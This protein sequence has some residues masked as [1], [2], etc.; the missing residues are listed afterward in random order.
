MKYLFSIGFL[1]FGNTLFAQNNLRECGTPSP[2]IK[3]VI[4]PEMLQAKDAAV[5]YST[6]YPIKVFIIVFANDDG[7]SL[8]S[9]EADALRQF[10]NMRDIYQPHNIC[11][12]LTG[13]EVLNN[14]DLNDMK[15]DEADDMTKLNNLLV[16]NSLT[17]FMHTALYDAGGTWAGWAYNIPNHFLSVDGGTISSTTNLSLMAHEMGHCLG[18][19]HTFEDGYGV[20]NRARSGACMDCD[21]DGDLICDTQADRNVNDDF[22]NTN[23]VYTGSL[24]D[25]CGDALLMEET[26]IMTYGRR[27]CREF[28]ST[29]QRGRMHVYI[30]TTHDSRV[31]ENALLVAAGT[32]SSGRA[33]YAARNSISFSAG[34]YLA[35]S[36][37]RVNFSSR[38]ITVGVG[39]T[40]APSSG[41]VVLRPGVYCQ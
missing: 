38:E 37:A 36:S 31:A 11:F 8:A 35:N 30:T 28:F 27:T 29:G 17:I 26:N 25:A 40:F 23:C 24:T 14:S 41:Y 21:V 16:S 34:S 33:N 19:L 22:I 4:S 6:P 7:S 2:V 13:Y 39:V 15:I 10:A 1:I 12:I 20:E 32:I 9:T 18:L 3:P 5:L